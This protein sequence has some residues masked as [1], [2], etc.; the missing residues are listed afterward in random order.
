MNGQEDTP[1]RAAGGKTFEF[2]YQVLHTLRK[3]KERES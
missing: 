2:Q 3:K 1:P